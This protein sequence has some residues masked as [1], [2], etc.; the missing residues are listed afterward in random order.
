MLRRI[1]AQLEMDSHPN[2][3]L[4]YDWNVD[5]EA[6]FEFEVV[7]LLDE[8]DNPDDDISGD[9]AALNELWLEKLEIDAPPTY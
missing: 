2:R 6:G 7:D 9:L 4:E 8:P 5:G 1:R 3:Q